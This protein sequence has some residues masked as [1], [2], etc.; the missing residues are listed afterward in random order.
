MQ[1]LKSSSVGSFSRIHFRELQYSLS[2]QTQRKLKN[3][4]AFTC[5]K[6]EF[7]FINVKLFQRKLSKNICIYFSK[8]SS[9]NK[10]F[11]D[12]KSLALQCKRNLTTDSMS[13][14]EICFPSII[15]QN[16]RMKKPE[17]RHKKTPKHD[18]N[19]QHRFYFL[20]STTRLKTQVTKCFNRAKILCQLCNI[21][22]ILY[23]QVA[24]HPAAFHETRPF[25]QHAR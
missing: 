7:D 6:G 17:K 12:P 23:N 14:R 5:E 21:K 2:Y 10:Y 8:A 4:L 19:H 11:T 3:S 1:N 25:Q 16:G 24:Y 18:D 20:H 22:A 13:L 15:L 9:K